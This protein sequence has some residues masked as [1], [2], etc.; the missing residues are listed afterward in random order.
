MTIAFTICC[1][2]F[3]AQAKTILQSLEKQYPGIQTIIFLVDKQDGR[4]DYH[5]F[6]PAELV[7]VDETIVEGFGELVQRY[8]VIELTT[9]LRPFLIRYIQERFPA[10]DRLYYIDPDMYVYDR[11]DMLDKILEKEDII[12]TPHF[13]KPIPPDG[14]VPFE[15]LALNYGT[16]NV[17]FFGMNPRTENSRRFLRWWGERTRQFNHVDIANGYFTDQIW[18]NLVPVFFEKVH[19][20]RH[21]G[22]NMAPWNLHERSISAY[23]ENGKI[24]LA[25]GEP[26]VIYHFSSWNPSD[27]GKLSGVYNRFSFD[28]RPD[29]VKLYKDYHV[30]LTR[31]KLDLFR[32]IPC[33]LPYNRKTVKRSRMKKILDPG[34]DLMRRVW[35]KI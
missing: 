5:F 1:N 29:L 18:F 26:L 15:N 24:R 20:L 30:A 22:Y 4:I 9:S 13:L 33:A 21:P 23:E 11:F 14:L 7:V 16:Y 35:Q 6:S 3:L 2:N 34:V 25:T 19:T 10:V 31:N 27:P 28:N 32:E 17:G 12:I 8:S